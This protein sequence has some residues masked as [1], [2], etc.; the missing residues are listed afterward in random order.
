VRH[1]LDPFPWSL[2]KRQN[3]TRWRA[4][5]SP[6]RLFFPLSVSVLAKLASYGDACNNQSPEE[7]PMQSNASEISDFSV[8]PARFRPSRHMPPP[9]T[10]FI[11][12]WQA[13]RGG[14]LAMHLPDL[15]V[16]LCHSRHGAKQW[17]YSG[18]CNP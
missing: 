5:E 12:G 18:S 16:V 17:K 4:R 11:L 10:L 8:R 2:L 6:A 15:P 7:S 3:S 13:A 1:R 14:H 9:T